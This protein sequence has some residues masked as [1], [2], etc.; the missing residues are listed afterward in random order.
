MNEQTLIVKHDNYD[1]ILI[2]QKKNLITILETG[3]IVIK[4]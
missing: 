4:V 1:I 2:V 3:T